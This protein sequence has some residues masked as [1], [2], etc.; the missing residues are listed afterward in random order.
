M[1][2][3]SITGQ[4]HVLVPMQN[5]EQGELVSLWKDM[6][7]LVVADTVL[8]IKSLDVFYLSFDSFTLCR[9]VYIFLK[10]WSINKDI[11]YNIILQKREQKR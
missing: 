10:N 11:K 1:L 3:F 6:A 8:L 4:P 9:Q 7:L 2:Q 5:M